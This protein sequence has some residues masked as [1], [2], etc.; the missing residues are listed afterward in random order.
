[1]AGSDDRGVGRRGDVA[2][3]LQV[4]AGQGA[5]L[6]DVGDHEARAALGIEALQHL[7]QVA[8][9]GDPA[10]AAQAPLALELA[11]VQADGHAIAVAADNLRAPL[12]V[13][14][15]GGADVDAA[16]AGGQR[17]LQRLGVADAAGQLDV[18]V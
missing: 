18:D 14:Q 4:R 13:L 11:D 5:V 6:G 12:R 3:Q 7:P 8:A 15:G 9:V 1:A 10:A 17:G 2:K 16:A